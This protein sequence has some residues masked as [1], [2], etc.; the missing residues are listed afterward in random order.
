MSRELHPFAPIV[1]PDA[2]VLILGSF[3]SVKSREEG[4]YYSHPRNRFWQVLSDIFDAD[5]PVSIPER[6]SFLQSRRIALWDVCAACDVTASA[7]ASI[8]G[9]VP[10]DIPGLLAAAEIRAIFTNGTT[11]DTLFRRHFPGLCAVK[12]PSTSPANA[13]WSRE[14]LTEAWRDV[15]LASQKSISH[16]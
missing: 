1:P 16:R 12:L 13:A 7:D 9:V 8:R 10:N 11:A 5:T 14:K 6:I 4:F 2:R 15:A 3:P